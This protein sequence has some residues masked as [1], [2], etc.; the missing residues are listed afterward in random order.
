MIEIYQGRLGAGK[1][2]NVVLRIAQ[3]MKRGG[4]VFGNVELIWDGF[5]EMCKQTYRFVPQ[6]CQYHQL[7][8]KEIPEVHRHISAG[9]MECPVLVVI[10]EIHLWFNARDWAKASRDLL[11]F[12]TQSRKVSIDLIFISQAMTNVDKQFRTLNEYVWS[13]KDLQ[14]L[15]IGFPWPLIL[16]LQFD[17]EGKN[18][19][20]WYVIRKSVLVFH[21]YK[22]NSLLKP[23]DFG[24]D[25]LSAVLV[26]HLPRFSFFSKKSQSEIEQSGSDSDPRPDIIPW[27]KAIPVICLTLAIGKI[28]L[29]LNGFSF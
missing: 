4:H 25:K 9:A 6:E 24:G 3:H 26:E 11:T 19:L 2:Y 22:T 1:T 13:A 14:K 29:C 27:S 18:L 15:I 5:V 16:V 28:V 12:L 10:D 17:G 20:K 21:S 7:Q 8:A 23:I